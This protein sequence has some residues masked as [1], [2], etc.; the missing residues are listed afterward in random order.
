MSKSIK[1]DQIT[2][3]TDKYLQQLI[4]WLYDPFR[5]LIEALSMGD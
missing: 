5:A 2:N 4:L 3:P 1:I